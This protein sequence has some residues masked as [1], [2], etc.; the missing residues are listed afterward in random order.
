MSFNASILESESSLG[1]SLPNTINLL[2]GLYSYYDYIVT[3]YKP[4]THIRHSKIG[5]YP[6]K[7]ACSFVIYLRFNPN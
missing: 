7:E 3:R 2:G 4:R 5:M 1:Q 6:T